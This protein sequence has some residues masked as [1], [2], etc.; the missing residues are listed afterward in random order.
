M[1][2]VWG[3]VIATIILLV[4][5]CILISKLVNEQQRLSE[6]SSVLDIILNGN[7]DR[8]ILAQNG[9][10][11]TDICYKINE[12]ALYY[13]DKMVQAEKAQNANRQ[14]MTNFSHDIRTPL[15][16]LIGYIDAIQAMV[17]TG[18]EREQYI[19]IAQSKAY[20]LKEHTDALF[21]WFKL[22]SHEELFHF[23]QMDINELTRNIIIEWIPKFE[24][25]AF[26]YDIFL[27]DNE[28]IVETDLSAYTRIINNLIQNVIQHSN[29]SYIAIGIKENP[30]YISLTVEDNGK[31][32]PAENLL[33]IFDRL[34]KCDK[35]RATL[36]SGLGLSIVKELLNALGGRIVAYSAPNIKTVFN[37]TFPRKRISAE[38]KKT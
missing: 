37:I 15:T 38:N 22:Y 17:V 1:N 6:I 31:G 28:I 26:T 34:Y 9:D 18:V 16:T 7:S 29:G 10:I 8:R 13:K 23:E 24:Q 20:E 5:I 14:L 11:T 35:S 12:I 19:K 36:G 3:F 25:K 2:I 4:T 32:I 33:Y 27:G 21:E 30:D